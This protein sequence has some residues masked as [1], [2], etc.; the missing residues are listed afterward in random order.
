MLTDIVRV[1]DMTA[2]AAPVGYIAAFGDWHG[3]QLIA[4]S[5]ISLHGRTGRVEVDVFSCKPFDAHSVAVLL[6][7]WMGGRWVVRRLRAS[8]DE[9]ETWAYP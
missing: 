7:G 2:I 1:I 9:G 4:E 6:F 5:H 8:A 3:F